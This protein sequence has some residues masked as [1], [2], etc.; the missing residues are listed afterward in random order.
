MRTMLNRVLAANGGGMHGA[1]RQ[2]GVT[3]LPL[4][5]VRDLQ[6]EADTVEVDVV[7]L[8][9]V[10]AIVHAARVT[11]QNYTFPELHGLDLESLADPALGISR[12][13]FA[14]ML[15]R[16]AEHAGD[17][18]L[19]LTLGASLG[20][21]HFHFVGPIVMG[22]VSGQ[23]AIES[24]LRLR[25]SILGGPAWSVTRDGSEARFGHPSAAR[26]GARVEAELG[27]VSFRQACVKTLE[28]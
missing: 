25:R 2:H 6:V 10:K 27:I 11:K 22:C 28:R 14:D 5:S 3:P 17:D 4:S 9:I 24:F 26:P 16:L 7:S 18:N 12:G 13:A 21:S 15:E 20:G 19:G 8:I 1:A 23:Q